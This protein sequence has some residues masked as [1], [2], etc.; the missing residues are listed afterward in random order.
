MNTP[1]TSSEYIIMILNMKSAKKER[2]P[3]YKGYRQR[4][5][6]EKAANIKVEVGWWDEAKTR[7]MNELHLV[8]GTP[9]LWEHLLDYCRAKN[10][11]LGREIPMFVDEMVVQHIRDLIFQ[12]YGSTLFCGENLSGSSYRSAELGAKTLVISQLGDEILHQVKLEAGLIFE[13]PDIV[14]D[15]Q[16]V[17]AVALG[18]D[19]GADDDI[20]F[21]KHYVCPFEKFN[22]L[23]EE[24]YCHLQFDHYNTVIDKCLKDLEDVAPGLDYDK[25]LKA[26]KKEAN[27]KNNDDIIDKYLTKMARGHMKNEQIIIQGVELSNPNQVRVLNAAKSLFIN[28]MVKDIKKRFVGNEKVK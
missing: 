20:P 4:L 14:E 11:V 12:F 23:V 16:T 10:M 26:A 8:V 3:S 21:E 9:I 22:Q 19:Y 13:E 18:T 24:T 27:G 6:E 15:P 28:S 7:I 5:K 25:V 17:A 2:I 1:P